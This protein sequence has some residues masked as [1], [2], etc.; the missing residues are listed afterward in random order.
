MKSK[1]FV[2]V[3]VV[4]CFLGI[5]LLHPVEAKQTV[6][7]AVCFV[8]TDHPVGV[9][10]PKWIEKIGEACPE[11]EVK[12]LGGPEV[13]PGM[14]Q[15]EAVRSG[16]VDV[17]FQATARY[18]PMAP[19]VNAFT[20]SKF[21][22][23]EE[24][25]SGFYDFMVEQHKKIGVM[26]L[27]RWLYDPFYMWVKKEI[28]HTDELKGMKMRTG[29]LY[30]RF[31]KALGIAPVRMRSGDVY[32][33]LQRGTVEG[34]AWPTL[35][36]RQDGWTDVC[37]YMI[38]APFF[39]S[40]NCVILMNLKKWDSF[41]QDVQKKMIQTTADFERAMVSHFKSAVEKERKELPKA[42][43]TFIR[44]PPDEEK[45]F[46]SL[47]Y[48]VEWQDLEKKVPDLVPQLKKLTGNE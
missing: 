39:V 21:T 25:E 45:R 41:S 29:T 35:G 17:N 19:A 22:P 32:T 5:F 44:L 18:A 47:A 34:F 4:F 14:Q 2:I 8:P 16:A 31:M 9:M 30:N 10:I 36:P 37:K 24:R 38:D 28:M 13:I 11:V 7:K 48:E 12:Y 40:Q 33:G 27:G 15:I 3:A 46:V 23:W 20:L 1:N 42:G 6:L 43:V 26:Y